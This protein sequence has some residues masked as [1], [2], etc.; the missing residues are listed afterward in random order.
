MTFQKIFV[1]LLKSRGLSPLRLSKEIGI[2]KSIVY[3]WK[4]GI[5]EP[6]AES[7]K[8]LSSYFG[9]SVSYLLGMDDE[10][11]GEREILMMLRQTKQISAQDHEKLLEN[12]R[13][14]LE[15]YLRARN[16]DGDD[17]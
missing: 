10:D 12:F 9:V 5:R 11:A 2:P 6:S 8:K 17:E 16:G 4:D 15:I 13:Q 1:D 14:T 3:E 7:L